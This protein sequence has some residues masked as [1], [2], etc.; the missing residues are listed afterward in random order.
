MRTT[1]FILLFTFI[2]SALFCQVDDIKKEAGKNRRNGE[3]GGD[4]S[5]DGLFENSDISP[6]GE[7]CFDAAFFI[8]VEALAKHHT[9]LMKNR[10]IDPTVLSIDVKA[11][12]A[13]NPD[14]NY[15]N[16]LPSARASWGVLSMDFR[17]NYLA[18]FEDFTLDIYKLMHWQMIQFNIKPVPVFGLTIGTGL[19]FE[20]YTDTVYNSNLSTV[21]TKRFKDNYNEHYL[22]LHFKFK[23]QQYLF[24]LEGRWALDYET[25]TDIF[26]EINLN[27]GYR[28]INF[29]HLYGYL[30]FGF[31]YQ[32]YYSS[33]NLY[34]LFVGMN[35]NFH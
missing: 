3:G 6:C 5:S 12:L 11:P 19:L 1:F 15:M 32:K 24:N 20:N 35:F 30:T 31:V 21:D 4:N 23:E 33:V 27:G 34:S 25:T 10:D 17:F 7:A 26:Q 2:Y 16:F 13:Y 28:F 22:G 8:A 9:Y 18:E 29:R 14:W